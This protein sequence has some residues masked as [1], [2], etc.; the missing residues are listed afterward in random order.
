[1]ETR[2]VSEILSPSEFDRITD[3][4][5][6]TCGIDLKNGKRELVQARLGK[7]IREGRF[8]SFKDYYDHVIADTTGEELIGVA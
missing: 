7:K 4:A 6:R 3:L 5:W 1:M 2:P 8:G